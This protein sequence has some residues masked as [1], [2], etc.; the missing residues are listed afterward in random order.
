MRGG[1]IP[2]CDGCSLSQR[3]RVRVRENR[4]A[5]NPVAVFLSAWFQGFSQICLAFSKLLDSFSIKAST[6]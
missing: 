4:L 6:A 3:E 5:F 2:A 1:K